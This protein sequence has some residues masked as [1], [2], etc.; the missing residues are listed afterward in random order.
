M[1]EWDF[2]KADRDIGERAVISQNTDEVYLITVAGTW[3]PTADV[4]WLLGTDF[5]KRCPC[6]EN[7]MIQMFARVAPTEEQ[8]K[9]KPARL[10][11][12]KVENPSSGLDHVD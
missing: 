5:R 2:L 9:Q 7:K 3:V 11:R 10:P 1:S 4:S 8:L 6:N 12:Y